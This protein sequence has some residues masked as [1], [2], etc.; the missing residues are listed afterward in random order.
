MALRLR[1]G[2]SEDCVGADIRSIEGLM[3]LVGVRLWRYQIGQDRFSFFI[4][5]SFAVEKRVD[6]VIYPDRSGQA[7]YVRC[8]L[9]V[10]RLP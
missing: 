5:F 8:V 1:S 10:L 3:N 4:S 6:V 7:R 2:F 9:Y